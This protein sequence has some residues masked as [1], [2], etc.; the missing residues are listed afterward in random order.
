ML[1]LES[2]EKSDQNLSS[3]K[4]ATKEQVGDHFSETQN[5]FKIKKSSYLNGDEDFDPKLSL[6]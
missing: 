2:P 5:Q 6:V 4:K 3:I 1:L